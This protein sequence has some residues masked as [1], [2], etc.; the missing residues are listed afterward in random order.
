MKKKIGISA[1]LAAFAFAAVLSAGA[2]AR[3]KGRVTDSAG[4]GV[5]GVAVTVTTPS[6][7]TFKMSLK[8]DKKGDWGTIIND[9]TMPYHVKFEK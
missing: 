2:Q 6:L 1:T 9:A 3:L 5:E 4:K 8:S 7:R